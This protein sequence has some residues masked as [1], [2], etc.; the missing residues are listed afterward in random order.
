MDLVDLKRL[1]YDLPESKEYEATKLFTERIEEMLRTAA[2]G[3]SNTIG[4][5]VELPVLGYVP[6][7]YPL[8][9]E[10]EAVGKILIPKNSLGSSKDAKELFALI[11]DGDSMIGDGIQSGDKVIINPHDVGVIN[12]KIYLVRIENEVA[13]KHVVDRDDRYILSSSNPK[14]PELSPD[15]L[16]ILGR[17]ILSG[18]WKEH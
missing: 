18:N 11:I 16:E 10:Q 1:V 4:E 14:Y 15:Q 13:I 9:N 8:P 2:K 17:V 7:G 12:G 3:V 5:L 6:A